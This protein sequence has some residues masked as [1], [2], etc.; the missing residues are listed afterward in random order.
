VDFARNNSDSACD[1]GA[2]G[3]SDTCSPEAYARV[4]AGTLR[5]IGSRSYRFIDCVTSTNTF[6]PNYS[7]VPRPQEC[8]WTERKFLGWYAQAAGTPPKS[9]SAILYDWGFDEGIGL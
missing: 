9:Y 6:H 7:S 1:A 5:N 8:Y 4:L 3:Y 2:I